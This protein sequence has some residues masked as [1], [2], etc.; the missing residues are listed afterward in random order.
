M[1]RPLP[2]LWIEVGATAPRACAG[3]G[4]PLRGHVDRATDYSAVVSLVGEPDSGGGSTAGSSAAGELVGSGWLSASTTIATTPPEP[5]VSLR[6]RPAV[7]G[8]TPT[9]A[10]RAHGTGCV[11]LLVAVIEEDSAGGVTAWR[12]RGRC[13]PSVDRSAIR[14]PQLVGRL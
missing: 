3:R 9:V 6:L 5:P 2:D 4:E 14:R 10:T 12:F 13:L 8:A 7:L 1:R 11:H